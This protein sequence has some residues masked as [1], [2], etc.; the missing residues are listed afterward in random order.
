MTDS[1]WE[2]YKKTIAPAFEVYEKA[3]APAFEVYKKAIKK[4]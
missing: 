1:A 4:A 2:V 3:R